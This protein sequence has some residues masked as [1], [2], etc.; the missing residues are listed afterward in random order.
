LRK[1][2]LTDDLRPHVQRGKS[3][4]PFF[5]DQSGPGIVRHALQTYREVSG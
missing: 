2:D 4:L 1:P 5:Q 3:V